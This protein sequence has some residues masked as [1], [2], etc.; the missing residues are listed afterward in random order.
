MVRDSVIWSEQLLEEVM[1]TRLYE[2]ELLG[3]GGCLTFSQPKIA[4]LPG[5]SMAKIA[6]AAV[7]DHGN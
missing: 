3:D 7:F 4:H 5:A 1:Q 6:S 2:I